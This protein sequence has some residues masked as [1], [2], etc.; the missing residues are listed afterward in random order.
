MLAAGLGERLRGDGIAVPKPLVP[1]GG[2]PLLAHALAALAAAGAH[3]AVVVVNEADAPAVAE[4]LPDLAAGLPVRLVRR[5][6]ASSLETFTVAAAELAGVR[7]ALVSMVDGVYDR[8][9]LARFAAR[10]AAFADDGATGHDGEPEGLLGVTRRRD[11]DR[12]LRVRTAP[13]GRVEAIGPGAETSPLSTAGLY[14]LPERAL[15]RGARALAE[16]V[17]ALRGLLALLV[18]EGIRLEAVDLG[19]VVDVDRADDLAAAEMRALRA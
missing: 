9:G 3:D 5:S 12:P 1:V 15:A 18:R 19:E 17:P 7:H 2:R 6:T 10:A 11:D 16:G 4:Q 8:A 14:L 13:D